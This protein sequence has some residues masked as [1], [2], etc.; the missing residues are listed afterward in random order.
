[1][2]RSHVVALLCFASAASGSTAPCGGAAHG[3]C[4]DRDGAQ[5]HAAAE[6]STGAEL[7]AMSAPRALFVAK[8]SVD[9]LRTAL[10][11]QW[12][13]SSAPEQQPEGKT[14]SSEQLLQVLAVL[15]STL[16]R[17]RMA[18]GLSPFAVSSA[19][20]HLAWCRDRSSFDAANLGLTPAPVAPLEVRAR[21]VVRFIQEYASKQ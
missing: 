17:V 9:A 14:G 16:A 12:P 1:M 13:G 5:I 11:Q 20:A 15:Y 8:C 18:Q 19:E 4:L 6:T 3:S 2:Q 7:S 21:S 10:G